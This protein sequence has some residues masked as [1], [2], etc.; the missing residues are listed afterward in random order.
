MA[1]LE[2]RALE[3]EVVCARTKRILLIGGAAQNPAVQLIAAQVFDVPIV[4]PEPGEY[5]ARG[6]AIQGVWALTGERPDWP[7]LVSAQPTPDY[8]PVIREQYRARR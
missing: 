1:G 4:V 8:R 6:A 5:V 2:N 7:L 3:L